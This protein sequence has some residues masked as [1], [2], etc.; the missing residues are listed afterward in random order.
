VSTLS[1]YV[2]SVSDVVISTLIISRQERFETKAFAY[3][4]K[5]IPSTVQILLQLW[6]YCSLQTELSLFIF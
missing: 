1:T 4:I 5:L 2:V 6:A 3:P